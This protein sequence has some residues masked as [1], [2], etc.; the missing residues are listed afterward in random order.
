MGLG[1]SVLARTKG[2][3]DPRSIARRYRRKMQA[4]AEELGIPLSEQ[5][6]DRLEDA[7]FEDAQWRKKMLFNG[8][9][10]K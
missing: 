6:L 1:D 9:N 5:Q 2:R 7:A 10:P 4:D 8:T 3:L